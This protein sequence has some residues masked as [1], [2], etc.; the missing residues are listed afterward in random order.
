MKKPNRLRERISGYLKR[1]SDI[2]DALTAGGVAMIGVGIWFI[3]WQ[4]AL[5]VMGVMC[6]SLGM[7]GARMRRR[8]GKN[9]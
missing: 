3:Y 2:D 6:F 1:V 7:L 5:I 4:V 9:S 8:H